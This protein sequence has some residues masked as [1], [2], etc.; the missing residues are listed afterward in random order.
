MAVQGFK[1]LGWF[2]CGVIVAPACYM[3]NSHGAAE[4]ARLKAMKGA[5]YQ[6]QKDIRSLET[7]FRPAP[8]SPR[9]SAGTATCWRLPRRLRSNI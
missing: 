9:S 4:Q 3:V 7:E 2:L 8:T 5:I 1:G 6:A